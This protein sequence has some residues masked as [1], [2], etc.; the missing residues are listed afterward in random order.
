MS[1]PSE[2][3]NEINALTREYAK[4]ES[5]DVLQFC[6]NYFLRRLESQRA[7]HLLSNAHS[8]Q[9]GAPAMAASNFPGVNPFG[10]PTAGPAS[11]SKGGMHSFDEE[12]EDD[13]FASPS[14]P[15]SRSTTK[16]ASVD[17]S[18]T[19][20]QAQSLFGSGGFGGGGFGG[21]GFGNNSTGNDGSRLPPMEGSN[22]PGNY[23]FNRRTSVSAESMIPTSSSSDNWQPP[24]HFKTP[25]QQTRIRQAIAS[26]FL[27]SHLDDTQSAQVIGALSE[28][29]IPA[30]GIK[31]I[32]QGDV[33]DYFYVVE[34]G[35][36]NI[37]IHSSGKFGEGPNALGNKVASISTG[38]S[39]GELALM[40]NAPRAATVIS[41]EPSTLWLLDRVTFRRI[42]ME[43]ASKKRTMYEDFLAEVKLLESLTQYERSKIA[44][45]LH[46][47]KY[48]AGHTIIHEG[49]PGD[50]FYIVESGHAEVYKRG[51][52]QPVAKYSKGDYFGELAL[53]NDKPRAASVVSSSDIKLAMLGK[54]GFQRLLGPVE[55]IMRRNDYSAGSD[56]DVDPMA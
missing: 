49:E 34:R 47:Q 48:P 4:Q 32:T 39:F 10:G 11:T 19:T 22:L 45:A 9:K 27:F 44:D 50:N 8:S 36:F 14:A 51:N 17:P 18:S 46:T 43:S 25:E 54:Q 35:S 26:N 2:L 23:H 37:H 20:P 16:D 33:G 52:P 15:A 5:S 28:K 6:S 13:H 42:L 38:G 24:H 30:A 1:L 7:E 40:Y 56:D 41:T 53:L 55:T 12:E 3:D 21:G 31:V 29:Q